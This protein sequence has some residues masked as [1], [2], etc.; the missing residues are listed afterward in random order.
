MALQLGSVDRSPSSAGSASKRNLPDAEI[1]LDRTAH[2]GSP[3]DKAPVPGRHRRDPGGSEEDVVPDVASGGHRVTSGG[4][5][6]EW[7][8]ETG[9]VQAGR[10]GGASGT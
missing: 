5:L 4:C 9:P 1:R 7:L 3:V 2:V 8:R 10:L 6:S